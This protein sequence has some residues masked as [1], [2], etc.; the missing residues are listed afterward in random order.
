MRLCQNEKIV[1]V[2]HCRNR[3]KSG[4]GEREDARTDKQKLA[5]HFPSVQLSLLLNAS[6]K[7]NQCKRAL[8]KSRVPTTR[9][10]TV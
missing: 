1:V 7:Y 8:A 6:Q 9:I 10:K 3:G 2:C 4:H 5:Q